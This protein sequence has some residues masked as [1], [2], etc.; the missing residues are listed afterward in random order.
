MEFWRIAYKMG[1]AIDTD[2][3]IAVSKGQITEEEKQQIITQ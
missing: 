2:L 3:D 1:W